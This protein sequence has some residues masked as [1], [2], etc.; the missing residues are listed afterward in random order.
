MSVQPFFAEASSGGPARRRQSAR[1]LAPTAPANAVALPPWR[2]ARVEQQRAGRWPGQQRDELRGLVLYDEPFRA[3]HPAHASHG[4][5]VS[6]MSEAGA[7]APGLV[8][9]PKSGEPRGQ[10]GW[11]DDEA[12]WPLSVSGAGVLLNF[13]QDSATSKPNLASHRS[14]SQ[15]GCESVMLR[16]SRAASRSFAILR[17]RRQR[18]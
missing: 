11:C 2:R 18:Q 9:I 7:K 13:S 1:P 12:C 4:L 8:T 17:P 14:T 5:P 15:R 3:E 10:I 16:Y 6:T